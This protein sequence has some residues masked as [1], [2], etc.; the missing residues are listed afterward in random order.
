MSRSVALRLGP[1]AD[2]EVI[3]ELN[4]GEVFEALELA[5]LNAWGVAA[6]PGLVGYIEANALGEAPDA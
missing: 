3:A 6:T 2:S 1:K 5:G 4:A